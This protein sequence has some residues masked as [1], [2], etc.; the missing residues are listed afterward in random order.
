MSVLGPFFYLAA[1]TEAY[2][3]AG[4]P[5]EI[6]V[7]PDDLLHARGQLCDLSDRRKGMLGLL[8]IAEARHFGPQP[9]PPYLHLKLDA[10][11]PPASY[12]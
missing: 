9:K 5:F 8:G 7:H 6:V 4:R 3:R 11:T 12:G 1:A 2:L 10:S